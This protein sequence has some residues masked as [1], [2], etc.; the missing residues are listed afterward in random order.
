M[1]KL[2]VIYAAGVAGIGAFLVVEP[3]QAKQTSTP[4]SVTSP[5]GNNQTPTVL[6]AQ[7]PAA[8]ARI[9]RVVYPTH[10]AQK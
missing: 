4:V 7:T 1:N 10:L 6:E 9:V 8:P 3:G 5:A 2:W